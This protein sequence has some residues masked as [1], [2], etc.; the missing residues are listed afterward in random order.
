MLIY[1]VEVSAIFLSNF[2]FHLFR[3]LEIFFFV[4][5]Y[6]SSL[7]FKTSMRIFPRIF[8]LFETFFRH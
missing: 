4:S 5:F 3:T 1:L 7:G 6:S 2:F 8:G